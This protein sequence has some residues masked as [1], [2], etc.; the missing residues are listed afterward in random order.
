MFRKNVR[1]TVISLHGMA[2]WRTHVGVGM[3]D[4]LKWIAS[5]RTR[6]RSTPA[7]YYWAFS[8]RFHLMSAIISDKSKNTVQRGSCKWHCWFVKTVG[9]HKRRPSSYRLSRLKLVIL[10]LSPQI[11]SYSYQVISYIPVQSMVYIETKFMRPYVQKHTHTH[12]TVLFKCSWPQQNCIS[13]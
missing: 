6:Q 8:Y 10:P 5:G 9:D 1:P 13:G 3:W 7:F 2:P 11:I 12:M 4:Q